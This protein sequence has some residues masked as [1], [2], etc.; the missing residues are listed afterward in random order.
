MPLPELTLRARHL[1]GKDGVFTAWSRWTRGLK[2]CGRQ[3]AGAS[4]RQR[5]VSAG[6]PPKATICNPF[7]GLGRD[8]FQNAKNREIS[9]VGCEQ[10]ADAA[11][12]NDGGQVSIKNAFPAQV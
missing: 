2:L 9:R 10:A 5:N 1:S 4:V 11:G 12:V 6:L 7:T 8:D 3:R